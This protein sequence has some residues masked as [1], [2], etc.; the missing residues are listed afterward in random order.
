MVE[1]FSQDQPEK[2]QELTLKKMALANLNL[3]TESATPTC[4]FIQY[5]AKKCR[6]QWF[7]KLQRGC[8][9]FEEFSLIGQQNSAELG[10]VQEGCGVLVA[11]PHQKFVKYMY[12]TQPP[13]PGSRRQIMN[14]WPFKYNLLIT[15]NLIQ[16]KNVKTLKPWLL[17]TLFGDTSP[18]K[19]KQ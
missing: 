5:V 15:E 16:A 14:E 9:G 11:H 10:M 12:L 6:A 7:L 4:Q 2:L 19:L 17:D 8:M 1:Y 13:P 3:Q 18:L